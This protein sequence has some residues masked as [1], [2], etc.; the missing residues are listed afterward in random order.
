MIIFAVTRSMFMVTLMLSGVSD[1]TSNDITSLGTRDVL[2]CVALTPKLQGSKRGSHSTMVWL[3]NSIARPALTTTSRWCDKPWTLTSAMC[4]VSS[5]L[6]GS[7]SYGD[8]AFGGMITESA[9]SGAAGV[10][11]VVSTSFVDGETGDGKLAGVVNQHSHRYLRVR[12][13]GE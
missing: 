4:R 13:Q 3:K 5:I 10:H 6:Y 9:M 1:W 8:G 11:F 7:I 2:V 12:G